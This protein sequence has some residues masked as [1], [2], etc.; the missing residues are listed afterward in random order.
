MRAID[1]IQ[2]DGETNVIGDEDELDHAAALQEVGGI[3][4]SED[5]CV[6]EDR[7]ILAQVISFSGTNEYNFAGSRAGDVWQ[8]SDMDGEKVNGGICRESVER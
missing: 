8:V 1:R 2:V 6:A 5:I 4:D 3:A 7:Q